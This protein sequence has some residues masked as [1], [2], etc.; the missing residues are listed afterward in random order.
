MEVAYQKWF[1]NNKWL[2]TWM[3]P[4]RDNHMSLS[5]PTA[6]FKESCGSVCSE[7][8]NLIQMLI[9]MS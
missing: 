7:A 5:D 4:N 1:K 8:L 2:H 9:V 3:D 6:Q